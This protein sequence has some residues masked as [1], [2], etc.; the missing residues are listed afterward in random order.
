MDKEKI[1]N[2]L[3]EMLNAASSAQS[4]SQS[5]NEAIYHRAEK[6]TL[7]KVIN[8]LEGDRL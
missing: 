7:M 2:I 1:I 6:E 8:I 3:T 4:K 5:S